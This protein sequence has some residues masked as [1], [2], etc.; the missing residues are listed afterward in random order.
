MLQFIPCSGRLSVRPFAPSGA[1]RQTA[2]AGLNSIIHAAV[3]S[4]SELT[5]L[6][7][8]PP[9]TVPYAMQ[10]LA[11]RQ[12]V[13]QLSAPIHGGACIKIEAGGSCV[14]GEILA[15]WSDA[16]AFFAR[17]ELR[18]ALTGLVELRRRLAD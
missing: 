6:G 5:V 12:M 18:E 4:G 1:R 11:G 2:V 3:Q 9:R 8:G 10:R 14:L 17:I 15:C 13:A 7:D 16:D